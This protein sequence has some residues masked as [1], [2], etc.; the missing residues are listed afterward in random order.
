MNER[1]DLEI[2]PIGFKD[3]TLRC[4]CRPAGKSNFQRCWTMQIDDKE[5]KNMPGT[6]IYDNFASL[7]SAEGLGL[8][9]LLNMRIHRRERGG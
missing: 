4:F 9:H 5:D 7:L 6:S 3:V 8:S 1:D 2:A